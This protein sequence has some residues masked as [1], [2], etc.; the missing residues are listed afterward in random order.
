MGECRI[1]ILRAGSGRAG[2]LALFMARTAA[3]GL[4]LPLPLALVLA[5]APTLVALKGLLRHSNS[6]MILHAFT[7][8]SES[9]V[10]PCHPS[11]KRTRGGKSE[12]ML[13]IMAVL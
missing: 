2:A 12:Y 4:T 7:L 3:P 1:P 11:L 8:N 9:R 6:M 5:L 13:M 10:C